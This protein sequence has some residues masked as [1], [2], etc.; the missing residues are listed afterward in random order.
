M[1]FVQKTLGITMSP[2]G[3]H[4]LMSTHNCVM[5][6]GNETF[7]ELIAIDPDAPEPSR[8]RW[9]TLDDPATQQ[10]TTFGVLSTTVAVWCFVIIGSTGFI[11]AR[12]I[13]GFSVTLLGVWLARK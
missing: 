10:K 7:F 1:D 13:D 2:G 8:T 6:A 9:L 11:V 5:Q 12:Q 3:K 4:D